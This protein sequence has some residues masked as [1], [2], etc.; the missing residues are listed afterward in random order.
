MVKVP[1]RIEGSEQM[2][3]TGGRGARAFKTEIK[4]YVKIHF[5]TKKYPSQTN[6]RPQPQKGDQKT[7]LQKKGGGVTHPHI[8]NPPNH[9]RNLKIP[10]PRSDSSQKP[11]QIQ[12]EHRSKRYIAQPHVQ[13]GGGGHASERENTAP[14][15]KE[16][17]NAPDT[18]PSIPKGALM[19]TKRSTHA[20]QK[21]PS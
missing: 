3:C 20:Y 11:R 9:R 21:P 18:T 10:P 15:R 6:P 13:G 5:P 8:K 17:E 19:H 14:Q 7:Y 1:P 2:K 12:E 16:P 4:K